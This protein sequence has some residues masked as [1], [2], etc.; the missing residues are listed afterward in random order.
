MADTTR[1]GVGVSVTA[2]VLFGAIS[3][4]AGSLQ[5]VTAAEAT[6]WRVLFILLALAGA[7]ILTR[8][9]KLLTA[10]VRRILEAPIRVLVLITT[11]GI[12]WAQMWLFMWAP[13]NGRGQEVALGYFLLPL[14]MVLVGRVFFRDVLTGWQRLAVAAA[15]CGAAA[16]VFMTG[17]IGWPTLVVAGLYPVYFGLRRWFRLDS[18]RVLLL[19]SVLL[20][21]PAIAMIGYHAW[22]RSQPDAAPASWT[23]LLL[24]ATLSGVA[25]T[26]Y[27]LAAQW[28][29]L[30]LFGLMSY[31]EPVLLLCAAVLLGEALVPGDALVYGPIAL[32]LVFLGLGALHANRLTRPG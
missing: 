10:Q 15:A 30:S 26:L 14:V 23:P 22:A 29:S 32:A 12:L 20:I 7:V 4:L 28:L 8:G 16:E 6:A 31:L 5:G 3:Y 21:V 24:M 11:S 27:I 2:S 13:A 25:M 9:G 17:S 19:E 1:R 18:F